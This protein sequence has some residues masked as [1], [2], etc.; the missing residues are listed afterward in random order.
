MKK[1]CCAVL[2]HFSRVRLSAALLTVAHWDHGICQ[3]R[4]PV[5]VSISF[6]SMCANVSVTVWESNKYVSSLR[7]ELMQENLTFLPWS[8]QI[9]EQTTYSITFKRINNIYHQ[10]MQIQN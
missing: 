9:A 1:M 10:N 7:V 6:S 4:I 8:Y 3:A 5:W 2:S